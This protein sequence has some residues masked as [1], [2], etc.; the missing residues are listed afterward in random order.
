MGLNC[1]QMKHLEG[2]QYSQYPVERN[3][4]A[5]MS[6]RDYRN[7][8]WQNQQP[9]GRNP[10]PSRSM[11]DYRNPPWMSAPFCSAPSTYAPPTSPSCASI[12]QPP[13][14]PQL[15][16]LVKQAILNLTKLVGDVVEEH[17]K[18]NAQL[19]QKIHTVENSLNQKVDGVHSEIGQKFDNLQK[20][21]SRLAQQHDYQEE[22]NP[23]RVCLIDTILG[24]QTQLQQLLQ[25]VFMQEPVEASKEL[26]AREVGGGRGKEAEEEPQK[27]ILHLNP[28]NL[29][30]SATAQPKNSPIPVYILPIA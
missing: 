11:R 14:S 13:Q 12:P 15:I 27:L 24:E 10:N 9:L 8:P 20:S 5:Y 21:I 16:S 26:L 4:G 17:K 6:M 2:E 30:P 25:E 23:E 29:D 3:H 19:S 1:D 22:E 7:L 28:I 18:F